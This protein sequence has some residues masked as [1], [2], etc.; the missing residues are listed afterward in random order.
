M[1]AVLPEA[2]AAADRLAQ[3]GAPADIVCVTRFGQSARS[4]TSIAITAWTWTP[5]SARLST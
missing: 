2:L 5:S 1:G 3:I 4:R